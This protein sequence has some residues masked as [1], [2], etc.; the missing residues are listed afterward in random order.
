MVCPRHAAFGGTETRP[1]HFLP[2]ACATVFAVREG[3]SFLKDP[4][5]VTIPF[6]P[7]IFSHIPAFL[8]RS[9]LP[10]YCQRLSRRFL[11]HLPRGNG[12]F[13]ASCDRSM[14]RKVCLCTFSWRGEF[15][16]SHKDIAQPE[17]EVA[18]KLHTLDQ[19]SFMPVAHRLNMALPPASQL[20]NGQRVVVPGG[21]RWHL[22]A[23]KI[24]EKPMLAQKDFY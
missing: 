5:L 1:G 24:S 9:R 3:I 4:I 12:Q 11:L 19:P 7:C 14:P 6:T 8:L 13:D 23:R 2:E 17:S 21:G 22:H 18:T 20:L 16:L 10:W 15:L